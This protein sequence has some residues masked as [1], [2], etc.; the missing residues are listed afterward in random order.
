MDRKT[1]D[2]LSILTIIVELVWRF[3]MESMSA[4]RW[5]HYVEWGLI[6]LIFVLIVLQFHA[7]R[8]EEKKDRGD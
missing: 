6:L 3:V 8:K 4:P 2:I 7:R 5:M 1:L